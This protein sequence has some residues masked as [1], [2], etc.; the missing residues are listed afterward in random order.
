[1]SIQVPF[2][3]ELTGVAVFAVSGALTAA[4]KQMDPL[5]FAL[6]AT[7]AG[8][9]GGTL[10]DVMLGQP[11]FWIVDPSDPAM[12]VFVGLATFLI[13]LRF[14]PTSRG[15]ARALVWADAAGL[16]IFAVSGAQ[17]AL[18]SGAHPVTAVVLGAM[19]ATFGGVVR[20]IL[21][22]ERPLILHREI[23]VTAAALGSG[24][25]VLAV[26]LGLPPLAAAAAGVGSAFLLRALAILRDW[27]LPAFPGGAQG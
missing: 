10:R 27:S 4:R 11:V 13:G 22:G 12:C 6:L 21:A 14:R 24:A 2:A 8:V 9:G 16:A 17:K 23:Y 26:W 18:L 5:G 3:L 1:M 7:V 19:T 15:L 25:F 20:D